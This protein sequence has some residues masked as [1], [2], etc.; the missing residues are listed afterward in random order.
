MSVVPKVFTIGLQESTADAML[1]TL[2]AVGVALMVEARAVNDRSNRAK[3]F[4]TPTRKRCHEVA[5][6]R[7]IAAL[8]P[9]CGSEMISFT[10]VKKE[11]RHQRRGTALAPASNV[12]H[13]MRMCRVIWPLL[14]Q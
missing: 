13:S 8:S 9:S 2:A 12:R 7:R 5:T 14:S 1:G 6:K 3:F 11:N 10:P 4:D